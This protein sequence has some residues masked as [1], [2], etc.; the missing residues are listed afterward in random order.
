MSA[1]SK[2][3]L[4]G[5]RR[6][7]PAQGC[8]TLAALAG[9]LALATPAAS[10]AAPEASTGTRAEASST[11]EKCTPIPR[12]PFTISLPGTYCLTE[13]VTLHPDPSFGM[14][15][16][17]PAAIK[18][19]AHDVTIDLGGHVLDDVT[20]GVATNALAIRAKD[21]K[22]LTVRNG[23][24]RRFFIGVA[25]IGDAG[26]DVTVEH[27]RFERVRYAAASI[28]MVKGFSFR[29]NE[30]VQMGHG[31]AWYMPHA[32]LVSGKGEVLRNV[33]HDVIPNTHKPARID[34][35]AISVKAGEVTIDGNLVANAAVP[36][37]DSWGIRVSRNAKA[38]ITRNVIAGFKFPVVYTPPGGG[39][40][41]AGN[42]EIH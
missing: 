3:A 41:A 17:A 18:V 19:L 35:E 42:N 16:K 21:R 7:T 11:A 28:N 27:V 9:G 40:W 38:T 33:I 39:E 13:D 23:T 31:N 22:R 6:R 25:A 15:L 1:R 24:I 34:T 12:V 37:G 26:E 29:D 8:F 36:E 32:I 2:A 14:R 10:G 30:L 20:N 4:R 5:L